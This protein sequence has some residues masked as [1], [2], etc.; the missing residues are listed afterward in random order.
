MASE[1]D[2][3]IGLKLRGMEILLG[4]PVWESTPERVVRAYVESGLLASSTWMEVT[5]VLH[6]VGV[7][8]VVNVRSDEVFRRVWD[9]PENFGVKLADGHFCV[10]SPMASRF[11]VSFRL[12]DIARKEGKP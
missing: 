4:I 6:R 10:L 5:P 12:A 2:P 1:R 11:D 8:V 9:H 3:R 7:E